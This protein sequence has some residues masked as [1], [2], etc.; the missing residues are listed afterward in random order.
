MT[1]TSVQDAA[2]CQAFGA[3]IVARAAVFNVGRP[4]AAV[5]PWR[6]WA[7]A[8]IVTGPAATGGC[9]FPTGGPSAVLVASTR[10]DDPDIPLPEGFRLTD[11]FHKRIVSGSP[12]IDRR[13]YEGRADRRAVLRF[14]ERQMPLVRWTPLT[15]RPVSGGVEMR[16]SRGRQSCTVVV[17]DR[18]VV[19]GQVTRVMITRRTPDLRERQPDS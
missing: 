16:F 10:S 1:G 9:S 13:T 12:W 4:A 11:Q 5:R 19:F 17:M 7:A 6:V 15:R 2:G 3:L 18:P 14:Y 8:A